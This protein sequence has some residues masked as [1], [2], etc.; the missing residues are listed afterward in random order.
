MRAGSLGMRNDMISQNEAD[1]I[2][3]AEMLS[4]TRDIIDI[5][6]ITSKLAR[7]QAA[8]NNVTQ[9]EKFISKIAFISMFE[10][11]LN[12]TWQLKW[13]HVGL[14][15]SVSITIALLQYKV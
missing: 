15:S 6:T 11:D 10:S 7:V 13:R 2:S 9:L 3:L 1:M 14:L 5:I 12:I 4:L 8:I